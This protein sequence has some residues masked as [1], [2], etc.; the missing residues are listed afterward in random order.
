VGL[1]TNGKKAKNGFHSLYA[2]NRRS[3]IGGR[4]LEVFSFRANISVNF[5]AFLASANQSCGAGGL[6]KADAR[7]SGILPSYAFRL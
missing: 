5:E 2:L 1:K 7:N 6:T 3:S 4:A